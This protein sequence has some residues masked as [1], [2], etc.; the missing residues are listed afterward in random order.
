MENLLAK[1]L[2]DDASAS[3]IDRLLARSVGPLVE[4]TPSSPIVRD[5][6]EPFGSIGAELR[7]LLEVRNGFFA[8]ESALLVR[9]ASSPQAPL[10]LAEWN[11]KDRWTAYP[12][13]DELLFFAED[14]FGHPFALS[15]NGVV[16]LDLETG[17]IEPVADSL[18]GWAGKIHEEPNLWTGW[19][20]AHEWQE[21]YQAIPLGYR[22][23]PR[24]PFVLG[25][26]YLLN[27]MVLVR[28]EDAQI[29]RAR[30]A[31]QIQTAPDGQLV[32]YELRLGPK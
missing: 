14:V 13:A 28:D 19:S 9:P 6:L 30:L 22:L 17:D 32:S 18:E 11:A 27:N 2:A 29:A 10:G 24:R 15:P 20:L 3:M 21:S 12:G 5:L 4:A 1:R 23:A 8:H 16:T 25:G 31:E 26:E 7:Q